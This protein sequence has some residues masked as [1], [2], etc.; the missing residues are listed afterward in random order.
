[1]S[2]NLGIQLG[3]FPVR[4]LGVPLTSQKLRKQ[5]YQPLI[6]RISSRFSSWTTR[7]LSF[8]GRLQLLQSV[9]YSTIS[10]WASIFVLPNQCL[11]TLEHMCNGFLWKGDPTASRGVKVSWESVCSPKHSGGLGLRRLSDWNRVLTLKLIWLIFSAGG[12]LWVSWIRHNLIGTT[13]FWC[14]SPS[15]SDSWVWKSI[16]KLR[17]IAIPF[18]VCQLGSGITASFWQDNWTTLGPLIDITGPRGPMVTGIVIDAVVADAISEGEWWLSSSR[19]CSPIISLLR[20]SLPN[21]QDIATSEVNDIYLWKPDHTS[22]RDFFSFS[23]TWTTL[24]P[25]PQSVEWYQSV[26]FKG[27]IPKH[28]FVA[29]VTARGMLNTRDRFRSWNMPVP[30]TC[31]L[32]ALQDESHQHLF[33][34]CPFS[35]QVWS[36]F[37]TKAHLSPPTNLQDV[38]RWMKDPSRDN[39]VSLILKLIFQASIYLIWKERNGRLH[40]VSNSPPS[41]LIKDIQLTLRRPLDPLSRAQQNLPS[42][43]SLLTTWF[44]VFQ[45]T[46][47]G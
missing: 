11:L 34:D 39:N 36:F 28:A 42:T 5:D 14:I 35:S 47:I 23:A 15:S 18:L 46:G 29:W 43:V 7:H 25:P 41:V 3:S 30:A 2:A 33:F 44:G 38:L 6:D 24:H 16:C 37:T 45:P 4:Y 32:C 19:S 26:W 31:L 40:N 21:A 9:I 22:A 1:M 8:A 13:N 20:D 27:R 17:S 10:F 12:S